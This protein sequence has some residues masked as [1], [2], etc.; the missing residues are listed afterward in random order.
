M[1]TEKVNFDVWVCKENAIENFKRAR[2]GLKK[3]INLLPSRHEGYC[4]S[5]MEC[6]YLISIIERWFG[7]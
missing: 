2:E 4:F 5:P 1:K 7:K 6:D 3:E